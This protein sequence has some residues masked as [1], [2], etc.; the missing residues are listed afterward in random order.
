ML[1]AWFCH[2]PPGPEMQSSPKN[3]D[4]DLST[5]G[6]SRIVGIF[7]GVQGCPRKLTLKDHIVSWNS[8]HSPWKW[9][10]PRKGNSSSNQWFS[11]AML[12]SGRVNPLMGGRVWTLV[13]CYIY[14]MIQPS[15]IGIK[16]SHSKDPVMHQSVEYNVIQGGPLPVLSSVTTP[17]IGVRTPVTYL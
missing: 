11:R 2:Q 17:I 7:H 10:G 12:V 5:M 14:R 13:S 6:V 16:L 8:K 1:S 15:H 9:A 4:L 3:V